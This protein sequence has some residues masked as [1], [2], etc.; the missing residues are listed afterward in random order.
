LRR[1]LELRDFLES[2]AVDV[3]LFRLRLDK[4]DIWNSPG[5]ILIAFFEEI[6]YRIAR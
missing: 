5:S 2:A 1:K 3:E 4:P 6:V